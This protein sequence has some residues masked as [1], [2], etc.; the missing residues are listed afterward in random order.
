[1]SSISSS[2]SVHNTSSQYNVV[3]EEADAN[4]ELTSNDFLNLLVL[5]MQNQDFMEPMDNSQMMEQ[6]ATMSNMQMMEE[7]AAYSKSN[8]ALSLVGKEVTASRFTVGGDLDTTSGVVE[9]VSLVD[10]EYVLYVG[11]KTYTLDQIMSLGAS[12]TQISASSYYVE[13]SNL[14]SDS[15][16]LDW[17]VPTEDFT[18]AQDLTYTVYYSET[19]PFETVEDV[20]AAQKVGIGNQKEQFNEVV[21]GLNPGTIYYLNV[22]VTDSLGNKTVYKPTQIRTLSFEDEAYG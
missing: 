13:S 17:Q 5:Q 15:V 14:T 3:F 8:Y 6:M 1:M 22:L 9:K 19:G 18:V 4:A 12:N 21:T 10:N 16:T 20:E 7:M 11:G 2:S